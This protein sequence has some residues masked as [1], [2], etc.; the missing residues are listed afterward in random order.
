MNAERVRG[1]A[2]GQSM[3]AERGQGDMQGRLL[4][5]FEKSIDLA[6]NIPKF[7]LSVR[8]FKAARAVFCPLSRKGAKRPLGNWVPVRGS[9]TR[10]W[11]L[12]LQVSS[13]V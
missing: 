4:G 11:V 2:A 7:S 9:R 10:I 6:Q 3:W 8:I 1:W 12:Y 13:T 5:F